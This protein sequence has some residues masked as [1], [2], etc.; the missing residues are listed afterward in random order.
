MPHETPSPIDLPAPPLEA[1]GL[2][3]TFGAIAVATILLLLTN[4]VTLADWFDDLPPTPV[5]AQ[6]A[7]IADQWLQLTQEMAIGAPR[8]ALHGVWKRA[9]VARF[10]NSDQR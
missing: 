7:G 6:A 3:W 9:E 4:A 8:D 2:G 10:P 1:D 5:Q